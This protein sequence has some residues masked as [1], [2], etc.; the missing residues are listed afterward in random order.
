MKNTIIAVLTTLLLTNTRGRKRTRKVIYRK[1]LRGRV[2]IL[3]QQVKDLEAKVE[4]D[5]LK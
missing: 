4:N 1:S 5:K 3:E 2:R